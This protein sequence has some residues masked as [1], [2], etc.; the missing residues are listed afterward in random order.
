MKHRS[1][2]FVVNFEHISHVFLAFLL[3]TL[4]MYLLALLAGR[5][6]I[7][8]ACRLV[9]NKVQRMSKDRSMIVLH[10]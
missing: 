2:V 5:L 1:G 7:L 4:S 3:L 6:I 8:S 9:L 10:P